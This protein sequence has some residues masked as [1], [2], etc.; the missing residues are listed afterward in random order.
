M[1]ITVYDSEEFIGSTA[2]P[3]H[4]I[5]FES[6]LA[7]QAGGE[8]ELATFAGQCAAKLAG[9]IGCAPFSA[10]DTEGFADDKLVDPAVF[11]DYFTKHAAAVKRPLSLP[12]GITLC[13]AAQPLQ[14][15]QVF[16]VA[17][18]LEGLVGFCWY[19]QL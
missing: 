13:M 14:S 11:T 17:T 8:A 2:G 4:F 15:N 10:H 3:Q 6:S 5:L 16:M 19:Q 18:A 1:R 12:E 7:G 9:I